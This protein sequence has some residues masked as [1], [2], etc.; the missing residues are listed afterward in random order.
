MAQHYKGEDYD[1]FPFNYEQNKKDMK[2]KLAKEA[3]FACVESG[4]R[5]YQEGMSKR[6]YAACAAMQSIITCLYSN[7]D[8]LESVKKTALENGIDMS[9][10][11]SKLA[12]EHADNLL[13]QEHE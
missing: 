5:V 7:S 13:K 4:G 6:F 2:D 10:V 12:F 3:A 1:P 8:M 9:D 11:V